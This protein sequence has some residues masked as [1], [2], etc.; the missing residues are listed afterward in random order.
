M[1]NNDLLLI[2]GNQLFP[3]EYLKKANIKKIFMA[4]DFGLTTYHKHHKLKIL[5]FLWAMRQYRDKLIEN[6][7]IVYYYSIDD[8]NFKVSYEDKLL[9]IIKDKKI[10]RINYFEIED[11]FFEDVFNEFVI[12]NNIKTKLLQNPMFLVS[13]SEF[14]EFANTQ[15]SLIRMASF[16]QKMR[17][18]MSILID[19]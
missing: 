19:D 3:L 4:E 13:R 1:Q 15:K 8:K 17:N 9:C 6:G 18:K 10:E 12:R 14:L 2:L 16:Y 5:M 11:H 7:Y